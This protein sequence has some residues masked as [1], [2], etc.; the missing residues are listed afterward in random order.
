MADCDPWLIRNRQNY[1]SDKV[2]GWRCL[3]LLRRVSLSAGLSS[4]NEAKHWWVVDDAPFQSGHWLFEGLTMDLLELRTLGTGTGP[5]KVQ[6]GYLRHA[7]TSPAAPHVFIEC[8]STF[9]TPS[10]RVVLKQDGILF[11]NYVVA[12]F[13]SSMVSLLD[14]L[15][16]L[17]RTNSIQQHFFVSGRCRWPPRGIFQD[18]KGSVRAGGTS[19]CC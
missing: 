14:V 1:Q 3:K 17:G 9:L 8:W 15:R 10:G 13:V 5:L 19:Q 18:L 11:Q 7:P 6:L 12:F 16:T 4:W 2:E